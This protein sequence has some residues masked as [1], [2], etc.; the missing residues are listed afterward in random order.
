MAFVV[1]D[2]TGLSTSTS[3]VDLDYAEAFADSFFSDTDYTA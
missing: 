2:G 3:Y 1:E